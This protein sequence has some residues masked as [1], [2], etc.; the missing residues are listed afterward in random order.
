LDNFCCPSWEFSRLSS[1]SKNPQNKA[2]DLALAGFDHVR[3]VTKR[4][5]TGDKG[6]V[7]GRSKQ[8]NGPKKQKVHKIAL[9]RILLGNHHASCG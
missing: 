7:F 4:E 6:H 8:L 3:G 5:S 2:D 1:A 9:D